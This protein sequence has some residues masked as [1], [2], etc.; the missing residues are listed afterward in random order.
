MV[1]F[2]TFVFQMDRL[3]WRVEAEFIAA[4]VLSFLDTHVML[5]SVRLCN[6]VVRNALSHRLNCSAK[7]LCAIVASEL[8]WVQVQVVLR[9]H[10]HWLVAVK[11]HQLLLLLQYFGLW[12]IVVI[13]AAPTTLTAYGWV[14]IRHCWLLWSFLLARRLEILMLNMM[15]CKST[16]LIPHKSF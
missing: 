8:T 12:Q 9:H 4:P 1:E 6:C 10:P 13:A 16:L 11:R 5:V 3:G 7:V 2:V 14:F 15:C